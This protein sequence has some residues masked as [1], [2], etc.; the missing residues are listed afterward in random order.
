[1]R[2]YN[3]DPSVTCSKV[4]DIIPTI[5]GGVMTKSLCSGYMINALGKNC[6]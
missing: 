4:I 6:L 3:G 5:N 2:A 1:M